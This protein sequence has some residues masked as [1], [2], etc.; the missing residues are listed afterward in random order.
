VKRGGNWNNNAQNCRSANRNRN[1]PDNSNNN[2]GFRP[3]NPSLRPSAAAHGRRP[4]AQG[5]GQPTVLGRP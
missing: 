4:R 1:N 5:D 2:I 3:A